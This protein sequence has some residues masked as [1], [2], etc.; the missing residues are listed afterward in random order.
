MEKA[1]IAQ[2]AVQAAGEDVSRI[3]NGELRISLQY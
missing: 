2:A 3:K 1:E